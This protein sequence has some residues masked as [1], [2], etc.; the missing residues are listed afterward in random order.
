MHFLNSDLLTF[1]VNEFN[2]SLKALPYTGSSLSLYSSVG[3]SYIHA[4]LEFIPVS[5]CEVGVK[6]YLFQGCFIYYKICLS[7]DGL[8]LSF[9]GH[10]YTTIGI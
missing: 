9:I 3:C 5:R 4:R 1:L 7:A 6:F 8:K 10:R 2:Q